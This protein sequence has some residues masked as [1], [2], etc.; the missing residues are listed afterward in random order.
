MKLRALSTLTLASTLL[1]ATSFAQVA[2]DVPGERFRP[3]TTS[4]G[5]LDVE[6]GAVGGHL[7][8]NAAV[9]FGYALNP[10]VVY[11][12][13][14]NER[15][16]SLI[17][18]RVGANAVL[19]LALFDWIE[20]AADLPF[21]VGQNGDRGSLPDDATAALVGQGLGDVR[22]VPK[23][24]LLKA[25]DQGVDLAIIP[26]FTLP[27]GLPGG[28]SFTG[29]DQAT[30]LP[31]VAVSRF[32]A[33]GPVAGLKLGGN[34]QFRYRP[35]DK[36][37]LGTTF[38]SELVGR[39]GVGY[40]F[41][42]Q[43]DVPLEVDGSV[44]LGAAADA[45]F[46]DADAT[47]AEVLA[48][49]KYDVVRVPAAVGAGY[50][51]VLQL[52][53]G[54]G[55]AISAG[56][57]APDLR[58]FVGIR[59]ERPTDIDFDDDGIAD[60]KDSCPQAA[61]DVDG[62]QDGDGCPDLDNDNDGVPD[63][64]DQCPNEM[65]DKD[66]FKDDD[67]CLDADN[68]DDGVADVEDSCADVAGPKENKGCPWPDAD[69]DGIF[70]KDDACRDVAGVA[71]LNG[72]PDKDNDGVTDAADLCPEL[73]GPKNL[74]G[75]PDSDGDGFTDNVDKCPTEPETV[76]NVD[77]ED[78]CPDE[79]KV[80]VTLTKE[81]I[82]ILDKVFFDTGKATIQKKSHF[83]LDQV[84]TIV[85]SHQEIAKVRVEGH[86]DDVGADDK[87]LTLS[88]E[89]AAAVREYLIGKGIDA[90]RLESVGYGETKPAAEGT[91]AS[92]REQNRRVEF[93]IVE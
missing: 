14:T 25:K 50:G 37:V 69:K 83:L 12:N 88:Q 63:V 30:F 79:G 55:T 51:F 4:H 43:H 73:A 26:A 77:D 53:G 9:W 67:G 86:T 3:S 29:E 75:C 87:N 92:A 23:L 17:E 68:D 27:T 2:G 62:W 46:A 6:S 71:A 24:R 82:V 39:A 80:L 91:S 10:L 61:E 18:Q 93:V 85:R 54:V 66:G 64:V 21:I 31:E 34:F 13:A 33:D 60:N 48:G 81:K 89:R 28:S 11:D 78:G 19:S 49:V 57:G 45:P 56:I 32:F 65:E 8:W 1:A 84:A 74:K 15:L 70:D 72:C 16:G 41:H 38:G 40:R 44:V 22:L 90:A 76:N 52:F 59:G 58:A 47:P 5:I 36:V 35:E 7:D 42:E 20:L